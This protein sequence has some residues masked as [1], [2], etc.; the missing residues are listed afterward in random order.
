MGVGAGGGESKGAG[1]G[2]KEKGGGYKKRQVIKPRAL[3]QSVRGRGRCYVPSSVTRTA[4]I[5]P[6]VPVAYILHLT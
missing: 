4:V 6:L 5:L 3:G 1:R 2:G